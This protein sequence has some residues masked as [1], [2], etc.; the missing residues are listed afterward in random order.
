M[1]GI[2]ISFEDY[3]NDGAE[4]G[5]VC[6]AYLCRLLRLPVSL[7]DIRRRHGGA[8]R[9]T[10]LQDL[11]VLGEQLGL[12]LDAKRY[13]A[14][15]IESVRTPAILLAG[16]NHF[17]VLIDLRR[18]R[19]TT[20]DPHRGVHIATVDQLCARFRGV[21]LETARLD[22]GSVGRKRRD[23]PAPGQGLW[24]LRSMIPPIFGGSMLLWQLGS[25]LAPLALA[26]ACAALPRLVGGR[27]AA[28]ILCAAAILGAD[29]T[30]RLI[31]LP[32]A[33]LRY[34]W[35]L[36]A[37]AG[38]AERLRRQ[39]R[40][41]RPSAYLGERMDV[42]DGTET[43]GQDLPRWV[44]D[45]MLDAPALAI[46]CLCLVFLAPL[47][48]AGELAGL[49]LWCVLAW[50]LGPIRRAAAAAAKHASNA[51][52]ARRIEIVKSP[53][54][55]SPIVARG[56]AARWAAKMRTR[57]AASRTVELVDLVID[58][59]RAAV[60]AT[61]ACAILWAAAAQGWAAPRW[62]TA[63]GLSAC[64]WM[65]GA[66]ILGDFARFGRLILPPI[67]PVS[68]ALQAPDAPSPPATAAPGPRHAVA[69]R[70]LF[71]R[72]HASQPWLFEQL[73]LEVGAGEVLAISGPSGI[74]KS[75]LMTILAG[76]LAPDAGGVWYR[77]GLGPKAPADGARGVELVQREDSLYAG[78]IAENIAGLNEGPD[79]PKVWRCLEASGIAPL[80]G[81]LPMGIHSYVGVD[82]QAFSAGERQRL[83]IARALYAE[84][85]L[86]LLDD[87]TSS[88]DP[89]AERQ[90]IAALRQSGLTVILASH[91]RVS[92]DLADRR[93]DLGRLR[94]GAVA[95]QESAAGELNRS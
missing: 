43:L 76:R 87:A 92:L 52:L 79:W 22:G 41:Q 6:V 64:V 47:A 15:A 25:A 85:G 51:E 66:A 38:Q 36:W 4:C 14:D 48:L 70:G 91:R 45:V 65:L 59:S 74:G 24:G 18:G 88:L 13:P 37:V 20:F 54:G 44:A 73:N 60:F 62:T 94:A 84:P 86:L 39:G 95:E 58:L 72:R 32:K 10:S 16:A 68:P 75:T 11:I 29:I 57:H 93:V 61:V 28:P 56:I 26:G 19:C 27:G 9:G 50:R 3:Q 8:A 82:G 67:E 30:R 23:A 17:V 53:A 78:S 63:L 2:E 77:E 21:A 12:S 81:A 69:I 34:R 80:V 31:R 83:L 40:P 90:I 42:T 1:P 71:F 35:R 55:I 49:G 7:P 89:H 33:V 5:L 46:A